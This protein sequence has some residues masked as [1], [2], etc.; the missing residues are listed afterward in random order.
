VQRWLADESL[1]IMVA[2]LFV[3]F[4][5]ATAAP[6]MVIGDTWLTFLGGREIVAHGLPGIDTLTVLSRGRHW[7]DQQWLAQLASYALESTVGL[8]ATLAVFVAMVVAPF[9]FACRWARSRGASARSVAVFGL[10]AAPAALCALRAQAFSYLL[11]APF[12]ALLSTESRRPSR[13]VWLAL[14]LL[15]VWANLHGAVLVAAALVSLLGLSEL[16]GRR[17][18]PRARAVGL[19]LLPWPCLFA[20][21][22]GLSLVGYYRSTLDNPVFKKY[23]LE[24]APPTFPTAVGLP[25]FVT[26]GVA[27][28]LVAR[29][30][31]ELTLFECGALALTLVGGLTAERSISWFSYAALLFLPALLERSWPQAALSSTLRRVLAL[32][33]AATIALGAA[34][35]VAAAAHASAHLESVWPQQAVRSVRTALAGDFRS[36]VAGAE[37]SSDWLLYE[38]PELRG[39][40]AFDGRFEVLSQ[41]QFRSV[42]NYL[43]VATPDW[44]RVASG[45]R[46]RVV[47]PQWNK[48]LFHVYLSRHYRL[49]YRN[50]RVAVFDARPTRR[51]TRG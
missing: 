51:S 47:D 6:Y 2:G 24:W 33:A 4:V 36:R 49:L 41:S 40:L 17:R 12:L 30:P 34:T 31:R 38:L 50:G 16:V 8:R 20:S 21:P 10:L 29:R 14:P 7:I 11:F 45:D 35:T 22:Y 27:L 44:E 18:K 32:S 48:Q 15:V 5:V 23:I 9:L 43:R 1:L 26:A 46:I 3:T 39:R 42:R 37:E 19:L 28:V 25:F 13:R